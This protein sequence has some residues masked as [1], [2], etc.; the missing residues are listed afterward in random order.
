MTKAAFNSDHKAVLD[1]LLL[2]FLGVTAG[3][4][5]G[6]PA[7]YVHGKLFAC[8]YGD[9]VGVKVPEE[10]ANSLLAMAH[11]VPFQ[12]MGKPKMREWV[13]INRTSSADYRLDEDIFRH[14]VRFV[15]PLK[16]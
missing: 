10:T 11:V 4:M 5:F 16:K 6:Y 2:H 7:Y 14:A 15:D 12:P 1:A 8:V 3:K 13:Q 9:G